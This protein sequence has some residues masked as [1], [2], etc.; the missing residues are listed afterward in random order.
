MCVSYVSSGVNLCSMTS[1]F[2][3]IFVLCLQAHRFAQGNYE[4]Q[5]RVYS[6][7]HFNDR[8]D[9]QGARCDVVSSNPCDNYFTFCLQAYGASQTSTIC[10]YGFYRTIN[11]P[12]TA[13]YVSFPLGQNVFAQNVNNPL[14]FSGSPAWIVSL[15]IIL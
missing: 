9:Y 15:P 14:V 12:Q 5:V 6:Y 1:M 13:T 2:V 4:F 8:R 10:H 3:L 11:N 7:N